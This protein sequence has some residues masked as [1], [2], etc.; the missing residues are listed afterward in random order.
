MT[1][2]FP[3]AGEDQAVAWL[4]EHRAAFTDE[5]LRERLLAAG[6]PP[7]DV[8]AVFRRLRAEEAPAAGPP[9][10]GDRRGREAVL[11]FCA[12]LAGILA[13]PALLA[14][15]GAANLAVV[16]AFAA[17]LVSLVGWGLSRDGGHP[18]IATG[19]GAALVLAVLAPV[20]AVVALFGYCL[21]A[22]G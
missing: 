19:L 21:V 13:V 9:A 1:A 11:A 2:P 4:R 14:A 8:D 17:L 12:A 15:A 20:V 7:G 10:S 6:H 18:G 3:P 22:G 16:V 5:A